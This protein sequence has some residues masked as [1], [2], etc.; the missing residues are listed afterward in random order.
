MKKIPI[1]LRIVLWFGSVMLVLLLLMFGFYFFFGKH[2]LKSDNEG[3][4]IRIVDYYAMSISEEGEYSLDQNEI[5]A[6]K[7][8]LKEKG[9]GE[10]RKEKDR[11]QHF[12]NGYEGVYISVFQSDGEAIEGELP[13]LFDNSTAKFD[14][15]ELQIINVQGT[16]WCVYDRKLK[17]AENDYIWV[18]G[19][20]NNLRTENTS[21]TL[22]LLFGAGM[23][24][25]VIL[26][27]L[28]GYFMLRKAFVPINQIIETAEEIGEG[29]DLTRRFYLGEGKDEIYKLANTFDHMF[30]R[31]EAYFENEKRFTSDASHEL[32]TPVSVIISQCEYAIE[33]VNNVEE[34]KESFEQILAQSK[35]MSVLIS[36]LLLLA[37]ADNGSQKLNLEKIN[38]SE[39]LEIICEQQSELAEEKQIEIHTHIQPNINL[40]GDETLLLRMIINLIENS[41]CYGKE[42]GHISA[43]LEENKAD[44]CLKIVD[45]GIG[46]EQEHID[47]I[48]ERFYQVD[49]ARNSAKDNSGLGLSMVKWIVNA[50]GGTIRVESQFQVGTTFYVTLPKIQRK[51]QEETAQRFPCHK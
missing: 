17:N 38:L 39:L 12:S 22:F 8:P 49:A 43:C 51:K 9:F 14:D 3:R 46:I 11:E 33:N 48:W 28:V 41:I 1:K 24:L 4:L 47:R 42:N 23:P 19:I 40:E 20:S 18:R 6:M 15:K 29:K 44:I 10:E 7:E 37:R 50:H 30:E 31:L 36:E 5:E 13:D 45:D 34:A 32:R 26:A 16:N 25:L 35:K 21:N 2:L 27:A